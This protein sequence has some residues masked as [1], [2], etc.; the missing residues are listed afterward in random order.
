MMYFF[1]FVV[2]IILITCTFNFVVAIITRCPEV[3][4]TVK[5]M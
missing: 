1:E 4:Y 2:I 5:V 3:H